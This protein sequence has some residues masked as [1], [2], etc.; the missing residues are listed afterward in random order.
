MSEIISMHSVVVA[1]KEG[2]SRTIEKEVAILNLKNSTYYGLDP[3]GAYVWNLMQQ[4]TS[5]VEVRKAM[6]A[7]FEI[8][9]SRCERELL[10]LLSQ[11][12]RE[13]LIEVKSRG[14]T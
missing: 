13:G 5:V 2:L 8:D 10:D 14:V 7:K 12:W 1:A 11:M 6:L 9:E 3:V 4:P